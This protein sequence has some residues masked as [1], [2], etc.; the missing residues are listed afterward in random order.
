MMISTPADRTTKG[1]IAQLNEMSKQSCTGFI[2]SEW[3]WQMPAV[4]ESE[5]LWKDY[6]PWLLGGGEAKV[7]FIDKRVDL[8]INLF[9]LWYRRSEQMSVQPAKSEL[10][11]RAAAQQSGNSGSRLKRSQVL[12]YAF[13]M[14]FVFIKKCVFVFWIIEGLGFTYNN[15]NVFQI[16]SI[17]PETFYQCLCPRF[18]ATAFNRLRP[19]LPGCRLVLTLLNKSTRKGSWKVPPWPSRPAR[20]KT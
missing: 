15:V 6:R 13:I 16:A 11:R 10:M 20:L 7:L 12:T 4:I 8:M 14:E 3:Q 19:N 18:P 5:N 9:P 17:D 1:L 2:S